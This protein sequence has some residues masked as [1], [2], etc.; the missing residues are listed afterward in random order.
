MRVQSND[1]FALFG[2]GRAFECQHEKV[3]KFTL[4]LDP[5][6]KSNLEAVDTTHVRL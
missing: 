3:P 1:P 2:D 5:F 4:C 6:T